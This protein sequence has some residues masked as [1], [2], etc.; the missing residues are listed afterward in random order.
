MR[1]ISCALPEGKDHDPTHNKLRAFNPFDVFD[2]R[3]ICRRS[4]RT[5]L[6]TRRDALWTYV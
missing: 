2:V 4:G 6:A 1:P 5:G 3:A